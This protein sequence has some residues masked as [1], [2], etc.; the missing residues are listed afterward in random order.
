MP[1]GI[2][3]DVQEIWFKDGQ[4][5]LDNHSRLQ[6]A[7]EDFVPPVTTTWDVELRLPRR[8]EHL[9]AGHYG[10]GWR[11]PDPGFCYHVPR[12]S[13]QL[14]PMLDDLHLTP[15]EHRA[16]LDEFVAEGIVDRDGPTFLALDGQP[17]YPLE[18]FTD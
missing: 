2:H 9:L 7:P 14:H 17:L 16:W 1:Y 8:T 4:A 3:L 13:T 11:T 12:L 10:S 15:R 6:S 18:R 5:W